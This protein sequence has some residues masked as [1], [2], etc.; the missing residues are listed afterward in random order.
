MLGALVSFC[1][2]IKI[3]QKQ[4]GPPVCNGQLKVNMVILGRI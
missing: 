1:A 3:E 2:F 4:V